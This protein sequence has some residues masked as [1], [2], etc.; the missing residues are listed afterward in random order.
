FRIDRIAV[1]DRQ[2]FVEDVPHG[3][4]RGAVIMRLVARALAG[5][6]HVEAAGARP[7]D[8]VANE[9]G[10]IAPCE[11]VDH[12]G[13]LRLAR[14]QGTSERIRLDVDH[15]DV[16]AVPDGAQ[17]V[18]YAGGRD[19]GRLDDYFDLGASDQRFRI[20]RHVRRATRERVPQRGCGNRLIVPACGAKLA[21]RAGDVEIA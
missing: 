6:D 13:G 2:I 8:V 16:L 4:G 11:A 15:H 18:A 17:G 12:A 10:L 19:A 7:V 21:P 3:V 20:L 14:E 1:R 5:G 9:R